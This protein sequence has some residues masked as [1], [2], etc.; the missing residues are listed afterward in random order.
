MFHST[1]HGPSPAMRL[2]A[3]F[4]ALTLAPSVLAQRGVQINTDGSG[5]IITGDAANEPS[6]AVNP[7]NP[8]HMVVAATAWA[9]A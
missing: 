5:N 7:L 8:L 9:R 1:S 6:F 4:S 3:L 2:A